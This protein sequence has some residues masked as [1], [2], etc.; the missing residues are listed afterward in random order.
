MVKKVYNKLVRDRIPEI[1]QQNGAIPVTRILSEEE[2]RNALCQKLQEELNEF[3][4]END[5][6]ELADLY[7]VADA[8]AQLLGGKAKIEE[9]QQEKR[10][11]SGAF[12]KRIYLEEVHERI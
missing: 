8:L 4:A 2:Y 1:I 3:L 9:L 11:K 10:E 7:E 12:C 6:M 5:P